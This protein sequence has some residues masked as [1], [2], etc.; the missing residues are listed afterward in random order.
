MNKQTPNQLLLI[1]D[2]RS[3]QELVRYALAPFDYQL[4]VVSDAEN[5]LIQ[6][7]QKSYSLIILDIMLPDING[8]ALCQQ[9]KS[10]PPLSQIPVIFIT[11]SHEPELIGQ[12]FQAGGVDYLTKPL[13]IDEFVARVQTHLRL[14]T[15]EQ[16]LRH[17]IAMRD[18]LFTTLSHDLRSPIGT[19]VSCMTYLLEYQELPAP[20]KTLISGVEKSVKQAYHFLDDVLTWAK[21]QV[22]TIAFKPAPCQLYELGQLCLSQVQQQALEKSQQLL[23][24]IPTNLKIIGDYQILRTILHNFLTN[25]IKFSP[26]DSQITLSSRC[27]DSG[28]LLEVEDSGPP[29]SQS[30]MQQ[31]KSGQPITSQPG[32][33]GERGTGLGLKICQEFAA[34]HNG[35]LQFQA[36]VGERK[37]ISLVIPQTLLEA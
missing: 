18:L 23:L 13:V 36:P 29:F 19:T 37:R 32:T 28:L 31:V 30:I 27:S 8:L 24:E 16:N 15:I 10:M 17:Q 26:R 1:E 6:L 20:L 2:T 7:Q 3:T 33:Q 34:L 35:Y 21:A 12:C 22:E 14:S 4:D 9:L 5:A 11:G 25:A